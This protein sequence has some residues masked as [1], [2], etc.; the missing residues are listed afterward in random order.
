MSIFVIGGTGFIGQRVIRRLA[1]RGEDVVVMDI[2]PTAA[3]F[4][5]LGSQVRV[6]RGDV[7]EFE[8]V[9]R[10][11]TENKPSRMINLSYLLGSDHAPR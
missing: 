9:M 11:T 3:D 10:I 7:T 4:S 5:D 8:D 6:I 1:G 2:N